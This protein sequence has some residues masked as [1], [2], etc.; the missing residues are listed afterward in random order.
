MSIHNHQ[1][2]NAEAQLR[3]CQNPAY[4]IQKKV[5]N[6]EQRQIAQTNPENRTQEQVADTE[7]R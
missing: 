7:E 5:A 2:R 3:R 6:T 1:K 4:K